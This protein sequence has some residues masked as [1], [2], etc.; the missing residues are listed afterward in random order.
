VGRWGLALLGWHQLSSARYSDRLSLSLASL[1][2]PSMASRG[3]RCRRRGRPRRAGCPTWRTSRALQ[4]QASYS[5]ISTVATSVTTSQDF[6]IVGHA[7][8]TRTRC[9]WRDVPERYGSWQSVYGL[10]RA[11]QL[12]GR[13][14]AILTGLQTLSAEAGVIEW[15]VS[16]DS[17]INRAHQH[18][19]GARRHPEDQRQGPLQPGQPGLPASTPHPGDHPGQG[20]PAD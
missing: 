8:R 16:V 20:R 2:A 10:F 7:G 14:A 9:P 18:A 6:R 5:C 12:A 15:V 3:G 17:T 13:W 19:A 4:G 11:W 1:I